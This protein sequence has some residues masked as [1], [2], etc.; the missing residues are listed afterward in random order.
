[1]RI[2]FKYLII[3]CL[4][5][6]SLLAQHKKVDSLRTVLNAYTKNDSTRLRHIGHLA[7]AYSAISEFD[8]AIYCSEKG[9]VLAERLKDIEKQIEF[10]SK[11]GVSLWNKSEYDNAIA[12][13]EKGLALTEITKNET[14]FSRLY[15]NIGLAYW[16]KSDFPRALNY[17]IKSYEIDMRHNDKAGMS[18]SL[19]NIGLVYSDM[20]DYKNALDYYF[21]S[22][23]M[24]KDAGD[25]QS[26]AI[27]YLNIGQ[28]YGSLKDSIRSLEYDYKALSIA[29]RYDDKRNIALANNNIGSTFVENNKEKARFHFDIALKNYEWI[30]DFAGQVL[31][32]NNLGDL[33]AEQRKFKDAIDIFQKAFKIERQYE[34]VD[35]QVNS[36]KGI[37]NAYH[38]INDNKNAYEYYVRYM[39]IND[40]LLT[41]RNL[42]EIS[43][44]QKS[45]EI[46]HR[47]AVLNLQKEKELEVK[48]AQ[49]QKQVFITIGT[50]VILI[51]TMVFALFSYNRF[52]ITIRQK[53]IIE[54]QKHFVEEKQKEIV[55][56]IRYAHRIQKALITSETYIKNNL[57]RLTKKL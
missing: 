42:S 34:L 39:Q 12:S 13:Y 43:N 46:K 14:D 16:D 3:L 50:I 23:R 11:I 33:Y 27:A 29:E 32:L 22:V 6:G 21:K 40:T 52:K 57:E 48:D 8:S 51:L 35:D 17:F 30:G 55:D 28:V 5:S 1:L 2:N 15:N 54:K 47:E 38:G 18:S 19:L 20:N 7:S 53:D 36:L 24:S 37:A 4:A 41:L 44:I 25:E 10:Y 56:S 45:M 31:V 9:L 49:Q 26:L